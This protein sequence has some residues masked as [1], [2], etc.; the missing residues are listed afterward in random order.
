MSRLEGRTALV[1]GAGSGIGRAIAQRLA[2]EGARLV[3]LGRNLDRLNDVADAVGGA[4]TVVTADLTDADA[5]DRA[6]AAV[7][8]VDILVN[9]A[10]IIASGEVHAFELEAFDRVI[11]TNLRGAFLV[12]RAVVPAMR[13]RRGGVIVNV[14]SVAARQW[15]GGMAAYAASKAGLLAL[16]GVLREEN[17]SNGIRVLDIVPG[18]TRTPIWDDFWPDAPRDRMMDADEVAAATVRAI[19]LDGDAMVEELIIRPTGGDL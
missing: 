6:L 12:S 17:R 10:G 18:A 2:D 7:G 3:L 15:F 19:T 14:S 8:P 11:S 13:E 1:T 9:A 4:A 5:T 16:S